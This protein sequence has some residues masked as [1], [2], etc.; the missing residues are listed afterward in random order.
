[1]LQTSDTTTG[2]QPPET[3]L[4]V[5]SFGEYALGPLEETEPC[6]QWT[7]HNEQPLYVNTVTLSNDG[8]YHHSNWLVVPEDSFAGD[9]GF[10]DCEDRGF[11]QLLAAVSGTVLF[12]QSTQS[13]YEAQEPG[14]RSGMST[15]KR[16]PTPG[17]LCTAMRP[18]S[19]PMYAREIARPRPAPSWRR[20]GDEST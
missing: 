16:E 9:D 5:H 12:A 20:R 6:A 19:A 11:S 8:G 10:F 13:R 18:P 14:K 7:L 17:L 2:E 1:M 15:V 3:A 4:L